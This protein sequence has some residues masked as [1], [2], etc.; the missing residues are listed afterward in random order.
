MGSE[1]NHYIRRLLA[2]IGIIA[3]AVSLFLLLWHH[4]HRGKSFFIIVASSVRAVIT[5]WRCVICC[6]FGRTC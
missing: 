4:R 3:I 1:Y 2:T 6:V 5:F